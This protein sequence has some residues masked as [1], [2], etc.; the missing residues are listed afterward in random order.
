MALFHAFFSLWGTLIP[1]IDRMRALTSVQSMHQRAETSFHV[2]SG[3]QPGTIP[4]VFVFVGHTYCPDRPHACAY[5]RLECMAIC[6]VITPSTKH[7][8]KKISRIQDTLVTSLGLSEGQVIPDQ[9]LVTPV[10]PY[11][12]LGTAELEK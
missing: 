10:W 8:A 6:M 3:M 5:H 2:P 1:P 12:T 7:Q 11:G 9:Y 4:S